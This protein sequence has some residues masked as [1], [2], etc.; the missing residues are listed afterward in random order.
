ML[1]KSATCKYITKNEYN[2]LC[3]F[4]ILLYK[5]KKKLVD[6]IRLHMKLITYHKPTTLREI[7]ITVCFF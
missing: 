1:V 7:M 6:R 3:I 4:F 5:K 2:K